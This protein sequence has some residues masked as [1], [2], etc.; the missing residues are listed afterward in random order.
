[1][2]AEISPSADRHR[3]NEEQNEPERFDPD[4]GSDKQ[5]V[6]KAVTTPN[7]SRTF[8]FIVIETGL[9][10]AWTGRARVC[11]DSA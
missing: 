2:S 6:G 9:L 11:R 1:M 7:H 8:K 3:G 5:R 10:D 4:I